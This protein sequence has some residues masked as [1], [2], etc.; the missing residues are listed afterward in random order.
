LI[1][2]CNWG[3]GDEHHSKSLNKIQLLQQ[4]KEMGIFNQADYFQDVHTSMTK[5]SRHDFASMTNTLVHMSV[6]ERGKY[7]NSITD[8]E[9]FKYKLA[10]A[11]EYVWRLPEAGITAY[12]YT[13]LIYKYWIGYTLGYNSVTALR[14]YSDKYI[15]VIQQS[16]SNWKEFL[17]AY[18]AGRAFNVGHAPNI[19][20]KCS[21]ENRLPLQVTI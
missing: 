4:L 11:N 21:T 14:N 17:I 20:R 9:T 10:I 7:I 18:Y 2:L 5:G 19:H 8:N 16:Y 13:W 3:T 12:D 15:P 1:C 6:I